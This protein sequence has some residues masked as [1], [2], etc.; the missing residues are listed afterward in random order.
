[1][2]GCRIGVRHAWRSGSLRVGLSA[3]E[4][5]ESGHAWPLSFPTAWLPPRPPHPPQ[6]HPPHPPWWHPPPSPWRPPPPP[7]PPPPASPPLPPPCSAPA[8][9]ALRISP[10]HNSMA[11][12]PAWPFEW[13]TK[14]SATT[15]CLLRLRRAYPCPWRQPQARALYL[16]GASLLPAFRPPAFLVSSRHPAILSCDRHTVPALRP[17]GQGQGWRHCTLRVLRSGAH[18]HRYVWTPFATVRW[19]RAWPRSRQPNALAPSHVPVP[20]RAA[21]N[22][23]RESTCGNFW[24][25][26]IE[27]PHVR[28]VYN[29]CSESQLLALCYP[30]CQATDALLAACLKLATGP[31][32]IPPDSAPELARS[33][34]EVARGPNRTAL[35]AAMRRF[36]CTPP[37]VAAGE[38]AS[39]GLERL[40]RKQLLAF[41]APASTN[42]RPL[43]LPSCQRA[44]IHSSQGPQRCA[45]VRSPRCLFLVDTLIAAMLGRPA[46]R[47][48]RDE[49]NTTARKTTSA[50]TQRVS[51]ASSKHSRSDKTISGGKGASSNQDSA[52]KRDDTGV[53]AGASTAGSGTDTRGDGGSRAVGGRGE[54]VGPTPPAPTATKSGKS[55]KKQAKGTAQG[56]LLTAKEISELRL[57]SKK[58]RR[59]YLDIKKVREN[60]VQRWR[61][62]H[63]ANGGERPAALGLALC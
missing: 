23:V 37:D 20:A 25:A 5:V 11:L 45:V 16:P 15:V 42:A 34:R 58:E 63:V 55:S 38:V 46:R 48:L 12:A 43:A 49:S 31:G 9:G 18:L 2:G 54:P 47:V 28:G 19:P 6:W 33:C 4:R 32:D 57:G 41:G 30:Q 8:P 13:A 26:R 35:C 44:C 21:V 53:G 3:S 52:G 40:P 29:W 17:Q 61:D 50:A 62:N 60:A 1:M 36:A 24:S 51:A 59:R 7:R 27:G 10:L 22:G 14:A 39:A 56:P